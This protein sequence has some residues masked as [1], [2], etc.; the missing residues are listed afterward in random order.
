MGFGMVLRDS[1]GWVTTAKCMTRRG[2][3]E[4]TA[5]EALAPFYAMQFTQEMGA[6]NVLLECD[7]L[8]VVEALNSW[9]RNGSQYGHIVED[10]RALLQSFLG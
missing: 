9:E 1:T 10:T 7:S 3:L 4:P 2:L 8:V 6:T 5:A